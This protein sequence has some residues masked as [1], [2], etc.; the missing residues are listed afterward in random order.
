MRRTLLNLAMA[1]VAGGAMAACG[2]THL[3]E[4]TGRAFR[5]AVE[6][7]QTSDAEGPHLRAEDAYEIL[8][9]L[10]GEKSS[11]KASAPRRS[12]SASPITVD[13][14][15]GGGAQGPIRLRAK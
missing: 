12:G 10:G 8:G 15:G 5:Q 11:T 14:G 13:L 6:I 2:S 7:Q 3:G 9:V 1:L 4:D